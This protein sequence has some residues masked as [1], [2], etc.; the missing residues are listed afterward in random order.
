MA[1]I[2]WLISCIT[3]HRFGNVK[4]FLY[5]LEIHQQ[6]FSSIAWCLIDKFLLLDVQ[7]VVCVA[8]WW[9]WVIIQPFFWISITTHRLNP[10]LRWALYKVN[11]QVMLSKA[12]ISPCFI[13][14]CSGGAFLPSAWLQACLLWAHHCGF[15]TNSL[16]H[17]IFHCRSQQGV[18]SICTYHRL[19]PP[20]GVYFS[21]N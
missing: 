11:I 19:P 7:I 10:G 15:Y 4:D 18:Q 3:L 9:G 14:F 12:L 17:V 13:L 8:W 20:R 6:G 21:K 16:F 5:Q 1:P 2:Q